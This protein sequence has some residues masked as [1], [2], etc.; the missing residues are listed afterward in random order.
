MKVFLDTNFVIDLFFREEYRSISTAFLA[1]GTKRGMRFCTSYLT[2]A[3]IAYIARKTE[4]KELRGKLR[5]IIE[6]FDI[7]SNDV[8]QVEHALAAN[9]SDFE[10]ALQYAAAKQNG[11]EL[12]VTRNEKDFGFSDIP[13]S[14]AELYLKY[15]NS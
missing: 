3:N 11:C 4:A 2:V 5:V 14:S 8:E 6:L 1:E 12:I 15:L 7:V 9:A 10:D 13:V